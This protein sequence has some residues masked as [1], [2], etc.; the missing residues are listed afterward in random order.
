[1]HVR[2][3]R[4]RYSFEAVCQGIPEVSA[5]PVKKQRNVQSGVGVDGGCEILTH[6]IDDTIHVDGFRQV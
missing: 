5:L 4:K 6:Q 1:M 2:Y 3:H